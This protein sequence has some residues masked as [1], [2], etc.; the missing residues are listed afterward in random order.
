MLTAFA[1]PDARA[2]LDD[3]PRERRF[4][5]RIRRDSVAQRS[6]SE[7]LEALTGL[8]VLYQEEGEHDR[9]LVAIE[10]AVQVIRIN[11]G[12]HSLDQ[13]PL[14]LQRIYAEEARGN[15]KGVWDREQELLTL[16][17]RHP[18]VDLRTVPVVHQM[19]DR[20]MAVPLERVIAG[21]RPPQ[22]IYGCFY[23]RWPK[24]QTGS[25]YAGSPQTVVQGMFAEAQRNYA[26]AV[27][28]LL[29][30]GQHTSDE[31]RELEM[32]ILRG[33]DFVQF[34]VRGAAQPNRHTDAAPSRP[35]SAPIASSRGAAVWRPSLRILASW[36]LPYPTMGSLDD[37]D[38]PKVEAKHIRIMDPYH[39]GRQS[40][41]RLYAYDA[42]SSST[43]LS[44][45]DAAVQIADWDLLYSHN[46]EAVARYELTYAMLVEA[47]V[48]QASIDQMFSPPVPVVLPAFQP[49]PLARDETR[50][51]T[52]H[53]DVAF[54][55]TKFGRG[56]SIDVLDALNA[57]NDAKRHL[58]DVITNSR[59]RPRPADGEFGDASSVVVRY[60]LHD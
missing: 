54:E 2:A 20:Q 58:A 30:N 27:A 22:I 51:A 47:G 4:L 15:D 59:F 23:K 60:Y 52:G 12:L 6:G 33:I 56:R 14:L 46:G 28:T 5:D 24:N 37:G 1:A 41:R 50:P 19:A 34:G 42:S 49:N 18:E 26:A 55:I 44:Q 11:A 31:V 29:R 48:P 13:V 8:I 43:P 36:Q 32:K 39:R 16:V 40:L 17:R 35:T 38:S 9:A 21:E 53:I 3:D 45:A 10:Q 25:C 7:L 57:T